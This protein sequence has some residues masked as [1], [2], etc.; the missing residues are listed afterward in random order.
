MNPVCDARLAQ[1]PELEYVRGLSPEQLREADPEDLKDAQHQWA[2]SSRLRLTEFCFEK[3]CS[4]T[5]RT[6]LDHLPPR[7]RCSSSRAT[8]AA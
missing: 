7:T 2:A 4:A 5:R 6:P 3:E 8:S 1:Y